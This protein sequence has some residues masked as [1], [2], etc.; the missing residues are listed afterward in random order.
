MPQGVPW[1]PDEYITWIPAFTAKGRSQIPKYYSHIVLNP[2]RCEMEYSKSDRLV[3][4]GFTYYVD[5][6]LGKHRNLDLD[7]S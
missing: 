7:D 2:Y 3:C 4:L 1:L 6:H 5:R